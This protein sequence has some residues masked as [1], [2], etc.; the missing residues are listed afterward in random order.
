MTRTRQFLYH[1]VYSFQKEA[2]NRKRKNSVRFPGN[3]FCKWHC[4]YPDCWELRNIWYWAS[5][6]VTPDSLALEGLL[7]TE[8]QE[9]EELSHVPQGQSSREQNSYDSLQQ[10]EMEQLKCMPNTRSKNMKSFVGVCNI[11]SNNIWPFECLCSI[12]SKNIKTFE[13]VCDI[14][15]KN[16]KPFEG[17]HNICSKNINPFEDVCNIYSKSMNPLECVCNICSKNMARFKCA[18]NVCSKNMEWFEYV[19]NICSQNIGRSEC[20]RNIYSKIERF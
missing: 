1:W 11:C 15:S 6:A 18:C 16:M 2:G 12:C 7:A 19:R 10:Y 5:A 17:V 9:Q 20:V 13:C 3:S 8:V 4:V 14:Y